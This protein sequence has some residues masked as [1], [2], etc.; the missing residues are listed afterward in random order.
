MGCAG[1]YVDATPNGP[2]L[3]LADAKAAIDSLA[4]LGVFHIALGGGEAL[5]HSDLFE[6]AEYAR[7]RGMIPNLTT[8][9]AGLTPKLVERCTVFGQINVSIDG[10]GQGRGTVS[11]ESAVAALKQLR[12]IKREVG[13]N[14]VVS[15]STFDGIGDVVRMAKK[16]KLSEVELLRFKPSGRGVRLFEKENL[17][18]EQGNRIYHRALWLAFRHRIR[19]KLD[20]SF[21]PMIFAHRP[22]KRVAQF[23]GVVGC[24]GGNILASILPNGQVTGCSFGGPDE[25]SALIP[26]KLPEVWNKGFGAFRDY[27]KN[28]PEPC[29]SCEY[30]SLCKGGCRV[31]AKA[32]GD[33]FAPDP[34]CPKVQAYRSALVP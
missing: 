33:W 14:C 17:T 20:C 4:E 23:L 27:V 9:G 15:R 11:F 31:V 10:V 12:A 32:A 6:I 28:A 34:G 1:C 16:L 13:I 21:A 26:G 19:V 25:G 5:L 8:S 22:S 2:S 18:P 3:S 7:G 29:R 24:E 30:L